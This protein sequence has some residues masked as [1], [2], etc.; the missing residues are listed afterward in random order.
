MGLDE[1]RLNQWGKSRLLKLFWV[2]L[3]PNGS[4]TRFALILV[5]KIDN[6]LWIS[7]WWRGKQECRN[8]SE[9]HFQ[10]SGMG[11]L[12]VSLLHKHPRVFVSFSFGRVVSHAKE[13]VAV[14]CSASH[15]SP[16]LAQQDML[17]EAVSEKQRRTN[18]V[19]CLT[20]HE[21]NI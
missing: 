12:T 17:L 7:P 15:T 11:R 4:S 16:G 18:S 6:Y 9:G 8:V 13:W 3:V 20:V 2:G 1:F 21:N 5:G 19:F 10:P 14:M